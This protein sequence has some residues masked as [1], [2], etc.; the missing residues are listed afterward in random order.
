MPIP[1]ITAPPPR[2]ARSWLPRPLGQQAEGDACRG[3]ADRV[4][5]DEA[6]GVGQRIGVDFGS[7]VPCAWPWKMAKKPTITAEIPSGR[8]HRRQHHLE[9]QHQGGGA[10]W[11]LLALD[12]R[13]GITSHAPRGPLDGHDH[14]KTTAAATGGPRAGGKRHDGADRDHRHHVV[15]AEERMRQAAQEAAARMR[16][17]CGRG[18]AR[19]RAAEGQQRQG[20][21]A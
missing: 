7:S 19:W 17:P 5:I 18:R 13:I 3:A 12:M 2:T 11:L 20:G 15:G 9:A 10:R 8:L 4:A 16:A 1:A 6:H 21:L 14:G